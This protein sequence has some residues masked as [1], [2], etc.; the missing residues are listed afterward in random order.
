MIKELFDKLNRGQVEV[1]YSE[2]VPSE[3]KD[4]K[5]LITKLK[6]KEKEIDAVLVS[7]FPGQL[8]VFAKQL[9]ESGITKPLFGTETM[10]D[11][12]EVKIS[13]GALVG[14]WYVNAGDGSGD[15]LKTYRDRFP[16]VSS[17]SSANG[18]DAV[19]LFA[20][21]A[22]K[23]VRGDG[24]AEFLSSIKDFSGA[25]GRYSSTGDHRFSLPAQIKVVTPE[26]F[27]PISQ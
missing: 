18:Y 20:A 7:L 15:F 13:H 23:G 2:D 1:T 11:A 24:L 12:N 22:T 10:E 8:G 25:L 27:A 26:G 16:G 9:R 4:F 19:L 5:S 14:G 21:A 6:T 3:E 17:F